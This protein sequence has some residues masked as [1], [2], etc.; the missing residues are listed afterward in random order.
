MESIFGA[1]L[2]ARAVLR[3]TAQLLVPGITLF[4]LLFIV[5]A[6]ARSLPPLL[7]VSILFYGY[8]VI[9]IGL[10][11]AIAALSF[12]YWRRHWLSGLSLACAAPLAFA[13]GI[14]PN[15]VN[16]PVGWTANV[17]KVIYYHRDLQQSYAEAKNS[18]RHSGRPILTDLGASHPDSS[19][20][21]LAKL[22]YRPISA[23]KPGPMGRVQPS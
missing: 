23:V 18:R 19:T 14:F 7:L 11:L 20:T 17:L 16:S 6:V 15:P 22:P 1:P 21:L 2:K 3:R 9:P 8:W 12:F 5:S 10:I 13:F 4:V